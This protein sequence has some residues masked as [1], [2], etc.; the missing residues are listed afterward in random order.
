MV[1]FLRGP[2]HYLLTAEPVSQDQQGRF[3]PDP[4]LLQNPG[5]G[6][7]EHIMGF[8]KQRT[9]Y[10][11]VFEDPSLDGLEVTARALSMRD[12]LAVSKMPDQA[13][14]QEA[15]LRKLADAIVAWNLEDEDGK[16]VSP[17]YKGLCAQEVSFINQLTQAWVSAITDVPKSSQTGS[18]GSG[19]YPELSIPMDVS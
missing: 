17:D 19:T 5:S 3:R 12:F 9:L 10:K 1:R 2:K 14:Q 18:N 13:D 6:N 7:K 15:S 11:L 16:P 4:P 8:R